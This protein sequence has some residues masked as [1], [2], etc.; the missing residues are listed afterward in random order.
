MLGSMTILALSLLVAAAI[1]PARIAKFAGGAEGAVSLQFDDSMNS[2]L[3]N[4]VPLLNARGLRATFFINPAR[5]QHQAHRQQWEVEVPKR[6]HELANHTQHHSGVRDV[7]EA[8]REIGE[9]SAVLRRVYGGK[10]RLMTFGRPGG[11]PW[12]VPEAQ[13]E[14]IYRKYRLVSAIDRAFFDEKDLD[15]VSFAER[16]RRDRSWVQ[17]GMHGTGGEWLNT[18]VPTLTRLLDYLS[19]HRRQIWTAPTIEVVKYVRER[20]SASTPVLKAV[21]TDRFEV[22]VQC[23]PAKVETY[24]L[25]FTDLYDQPLTVEVEVP[26]TWRSVVLPQGRVATRF[27]GT[28]TMALVEVL[29]N[30]GTVTVRKG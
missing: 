10:P 5:P 12:E 30:R 15:P 3:E 27:D 28:K 19:G 7:A 13:L 8:E 29:P 16:A 26:D 4:A 6:G 24:G 1:G 21:G 18:S 14:P 20:D 2:Q 11:V 9:C 22:S 25:A 17:I 23:E